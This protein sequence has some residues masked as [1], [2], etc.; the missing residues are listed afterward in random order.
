MPHWDT[1]A[2]H[3]QPRIRKHLKD[4]Y[5]QPQ[6]K[7]TNIIFRQD[8]NIPLLRILLIDPLLRPPGDWGLR[9]P[10]ARASECVRRVEASGPRSPPGGCHHPLRAAR[11]GAGPHRWVPTVRCLCHNAQCHMRDGGSD[12]KCWQ[13]PSH[14]TCISYTCTHVAS[15]ILSR[16]YYSIRFQARKPPLFKSP[17]RNSMS[18]VGSSS[19]LAIMMLLD[20]SS[21]SSSPQIL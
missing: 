6:I 10:W 14:F 2:S 18:S 1:G 19:A 17:P 21:W 12:I 8:S 9:V 15:K 4:N 13:T 16:Q 11:A 20:S 5:V 7:N 3:W